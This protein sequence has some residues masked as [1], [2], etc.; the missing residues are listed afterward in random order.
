MDT[1][2]KLIAAGQFKQH[3]LAI[4]D[5]VAKTHQPVVISKRGKPMARLVPVSTDEEIEG[6]ILARLRTG[7]GGMQVDEKT[8][9]EPSS[10][11]AGWPE[12]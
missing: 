4:I 6:H 8:F 9:L 10:R 11:I 3:C 7:E 12:T 2:E 1:K 5:E